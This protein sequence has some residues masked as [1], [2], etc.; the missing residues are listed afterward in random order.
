[1]IDSTIIKGYF[2]I[3]GESIVLVTT[4]TVFQGEA[5]YSCIEG[6]RLEG[7]SIRKCMATGKWSGQDP[8][9]EI[10]RCPDPLKVPHA[11]LIYSDNR[12]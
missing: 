1:M 11:Y 12:Y 8:S 4:S 3:Q 7:P 9:C 10:I 5:K 6:F 2:S